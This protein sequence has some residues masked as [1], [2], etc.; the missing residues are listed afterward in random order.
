MKNNQ[1]KQ[2]NYGKILD[3]IQKRNE[4]KNQII[5]ILQST[6][7][8][9]IEDI[10][11][12]IGINRNTFNY[13]IN[14]FEKEKWIHRRLIECEGKEK[15]GSPKT[16]VLDKKF[17]EWQKTL[18]NRS[19]ESYEE[20]QLEE[21]LVRRIIELVDEKKSSEKQYREL[22]KLFKKFNKE[23][24]GAKFIFLIY[25]DFVKIDFNL[26]LTEKGRKALSKIKKKSKK[27]ASP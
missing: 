6:E 1:Y 13:W 11:K 18:K 7:N 15:R 3:R 23:S 2:N 22:A 8:L 21:I 12:K 9:A 14:K 10:R 4:I 24:Y 17:I 5:D 25:D 27:K 16:L 19:W 20:K 26:S